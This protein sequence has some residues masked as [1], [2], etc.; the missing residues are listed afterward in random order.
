MSPARTAARR[1]PA[2]P[3]PSRQRRSSGRARALFARWWPALLLVA[4]V[5]AGAA[6]SGGGAAAPQAAGVC[7]VPLSS[8]TVTAEQAANAATIAEVATARGLPDRA[9]VIALATARQESGLRNLDHGDR[10]SLGLFQQR[11]SQGWGTP[12]Q[13]RDPVYAA[14]EF[15]ERLVGVPNWQTGRLTDVAQT[16]QRSGFPEAYQKHEAIAVALTAALRA[17][18]GRLDCG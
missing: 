8:E 9:V 17:G 18:D 12:E 11:P 16:V 5:L 7:A 4:A 13:V 3:S 1:A 6:W 10:D 15:Y 14:G 2:R